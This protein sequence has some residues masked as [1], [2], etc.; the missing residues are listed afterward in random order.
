MR[1][2]SSDAPSRAPSSRPALMP[3]GRK[4]SPMPSGRLLTGPH[5]DACVWLTHFDDAILCLPS[6]AG[7][8]A[9]ATLS[10]STSPLTVDA[11]AVREER[12]K[13]IP[14]QYAL[15]A[16]YY[17]S[18]WT[19]GRTAPPGGGGLA[20]MGT[21]EGGRHR[22][23]PRRARHGF[24]TPPTSATVSASRATDRAGVPSVPIRRDGD[25][26]ADDYRPRYLPP[27]WTRACRRRTPSQPHRD[28]RSQK[29]SN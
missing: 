12:T 14:Q 6:A 26:D 16:T 27:C 9:N 22:V 19:G 3:S 5:Y 7:P 29:T 25:W 1:S 23:G 24:R 28:F 4:A 11:S 15:V 8:I 21:T 10:S 20:T 18:T 2:A 17:A 13:R